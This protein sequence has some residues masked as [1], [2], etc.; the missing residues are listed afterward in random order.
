MTKT[1]RPI[2]VLVT[3]GRETTLK[4]LGLDPAAICVLVVKTLNQISDCGRRPTTV[5]HG[6]AKG[7]DSYADNWCAGT[8]TPKLCFPVSKDDWESK[9]NI[10]GNLRNTQMLN[11]GK[12]DVCLAFPGGGGTADMVMKCCDAGVRVVPVGLEVKA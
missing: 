2:R 9:G 10:A 12:P 1:L 7:V 4:K 8:R 5:I 6:G 11:D 3:G